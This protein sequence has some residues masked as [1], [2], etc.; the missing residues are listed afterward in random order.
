ML[1]ANQTMNGFQTITEEADWE[2]YNELEETKDEE[3]DE[4]DDLGWDENIFET[5]FNKLL[6][7]Q[8]R[9]THT[10]MMSNRIV[11]NWNL[12]KKLMI[13]I[14]KIIKND[15]N[16]WE[17]EE[18][19]ILTN[20]KGVKKK[21]PFI[22]I[23]IESNK[24]HRVLMK[25]STLSFPYNYDASKRNWKTP[26]LLLQYKAL[27]LHQE[28]FKVY[29][30][31]HIDGK[32]NIWISK[33]GYNS[34]GVGI[35]IINSLKDVISAGRKAQS[36]RIMQKYI[37]WPFLLKYPISNPQPG[38]KK[39]EKR[40]F[41][42]RQWVL[43]TSYE[44]LWVYVF[45]SAY[46]R[47]CG[48]EF[49]LYDISDNFRH[50]SNY[51]VQKKNKRVEN[52]KTDL[53]LSSSQFEEYVKKYSNPNFTW[54]EG[55]FPKIKKVVVETLKAG[56]ENIKHRNNWFE[57]YG[58]DF[59]LDQELNPWLIEV[60]L[61]PAW[62]QRTEYL[63]EMLESMADGI[64]DFVETK[65][66]LMK[67]NI[68][69][70]SKPS[71]VLPFPKMEEYDSI[72][73]DDSIQEGKTT[74]NW[75]LVYFEKNKLNSF[76]GA[77][78]KKGTNLELFGSKANIK[79]EK[80][81]DKLYQKYM[82]VLFIQ[83]IYRGHLARK[84]VLLMRMTISAV[85]YQKYTRRWLA[86]RE[87]IRRRRNKAAIAIQTKIR[88][89]LAKYELASRKAEWILKQKIYVWIKIQSHFRRK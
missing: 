4:E 17:E 57:L 79:E 25:Y 60:N 51:T 37:E 54:K 21:S 40:K 31:Y 80:K 34:R 53:S 68:E 35:H 22:K 84:R 36:H 71:P 74:D 28:L 86:K 5:S 48:S 56:Q 9:Q 3:L 41:D 1:S 2:E 8:F 89:I 77:I 62:A 55:M 43:V 42:I 44:P 85:I 58:F 76:N 23:N 14:N 29:P 27:K 16:D 7:D 73:V 19:Y 45:S 63:K 46:L 12:L 72:W 78:A 82:S 13:M 30:Q 38:Q 52:R 83:K 32:Q 39:Y 61:S 18:Y 11:V 20:R 70:I 26:S 15:T 65:I 49:S 64:L 75:V 6:D 50:I 69:Q 88:V 66:S 24:L 10:S 33:P 59:I 81:L 47:I 87:L 67:R